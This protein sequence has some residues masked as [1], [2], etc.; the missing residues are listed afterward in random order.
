MAQAARAKPSTGSTTTAPSGKR[1]LGM[2]AAAEYVGVGQ[3]T[4]NKWIHEYP[5][6]IPYY[7]DGIYRFAIADLD[8]YLASIYVNGGEEAV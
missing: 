7:F 6:R 5:P 2:K 8:K 1:F 4:M 3:S